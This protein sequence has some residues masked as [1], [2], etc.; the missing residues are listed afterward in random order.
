MNISPEERFLHLKYANFLC[1]I[2]NNMITHKKEVEKRD[3]KNDTGEVERS[4]PA[5]YHSS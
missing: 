2:K 3:R 4:F 1:I 5:F